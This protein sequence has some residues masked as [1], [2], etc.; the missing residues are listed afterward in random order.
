MKIAYIVPHLSTPSGWRTACLGIIKALMTYATVKPVI[1]VSA[2]DKIAAQ[3]LFPEEIIIDLPKIQSQGLNQDGWQD[4]LLTYWRFRHLKFPPVDL[5]HSLE[6][7]PTGLIGHWLAKSLN[8]P[9]IL[10]GYG[11]YA[12]KWHVHKLDRLG[13]VYQDLLQD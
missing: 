5:V 9:H 2:S 8:V 10:T 12:V 3:E 1:I 7:Y 13:E 6:A 11:T 4:V